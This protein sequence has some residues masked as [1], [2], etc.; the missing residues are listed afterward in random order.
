MRDPKKV[1]ENLQKIANI[2]A[3]DGA[4][5]TMTVIGDAIKLLKEW[6]A[7]HILIERARR[8]EIVLDYPTPEQMRDTKWEG[9]SD[10]E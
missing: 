1:I 2:C 9:D 10:A 3:Q 5:Q 4:I 8:G 7:D 6:E